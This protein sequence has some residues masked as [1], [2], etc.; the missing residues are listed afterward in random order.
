MMSTVPSTSRDT[1]RDNVR[2][3]G[4]WLYFK[5][6]GEPRKGTL[7]CLH[8]GPGGTHQSTLPMSKL[9]EDGYQV[10]MYDQRGC[11]ASEQPG[12]PESGT[13]RR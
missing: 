12:P 2:V 1:L 7:L 4:Y 6:F 13:V 9:S 8:G 5:S 11:G 10:V 3:L